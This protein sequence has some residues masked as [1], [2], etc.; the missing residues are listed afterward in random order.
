[1]TDR[2]YEDEPTPFRVLAA[3]AMPPAKLIR[4]WAQAKGLPVGKRGRISSDVELAYLQA[5]G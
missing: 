2:D 1:M 5:R 4:Q 3:P